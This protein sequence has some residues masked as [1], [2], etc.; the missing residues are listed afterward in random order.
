MNA[1]PSPVQA[2]DELDHLAFSAAGVEGGEEDS[3]R[4]MGTSVHKRPSQQGK[5]HEECIAVVLLW[6]V[7]FTFPVNRCSGFGER[8]EVCIKMPFVTPLPPQ[9][10]EVRPAVLAAGTPGEST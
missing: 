4:N 8:G 10:Y 3:N 9:P 6:R 5:C 1:K 7:F 2:T